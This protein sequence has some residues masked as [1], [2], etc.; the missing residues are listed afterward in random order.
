[1]K[2]KLKRLRDGMFDFKITR[3][4]MK[5]SNDENICIDPQLESYIN[6][7]TVTPI[8]PGIAELSTLFVPYMKQIISLQDQKR[9]S[10]NSQTGDISIYMNQ[11]LNFVLSSH[12]EYMVR[13]M[14]NTN[15][16]TN[17][18]TI[19]LKNINLEFSQLQYQQHYSHKKALDTQFDNHS[20]SNEND[21]IE[22]FC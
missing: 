12:L 10:L 9:K 7:T 4:D 14:T 11:S 20:H 2:D 1:M 15:T 21:D 19:E 18:K 5:S 3:S 22:E 16:N 6:T 13:S 17:T 8:R